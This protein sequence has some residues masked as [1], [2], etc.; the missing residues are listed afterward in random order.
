MIEESFTSKPLLEPRPIRDFLDRMPKFQIYQWVFGVVF[1]LVYLMVFSFF[2]LVATFFQSEVV[3]F[4][5]F[6]PYI[7]VL[8]ISLIWPLRSAVC[9]GILHSVSSALILLSPLTVI[10]LPVFLVRSFSDIFGASL[11]DG[12]LYLAFA[13]FLGVPFTAHV[14]LHN[15]K[16]IIARNTDPKWIRRVLFYVSA[17]LGVFLW[18]AV[19][20]CVFIVQILEG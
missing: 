7:L 12:I 10:I 16:Q 2:F 18:G 9:A 19:P 6:L 3:L 20:A 13:C 4:F 11:L 5:Y 15:A 1:P 14:Y 17:F 8:A